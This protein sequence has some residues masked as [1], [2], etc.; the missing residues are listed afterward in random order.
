MAGFVV[1]FLVGIVCI[2]L[3]ASNM[4]GNIS[5]LHAYHRNRV[6][7]EDRV[8]FGKQVGLGTIMIGIGIMVFSALSAVT[9]YTEKDIFLLIGTVLLIGSIIAGLVLSFRAMIKYNTGIF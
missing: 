5:S 2:F 4:Q 1:T 6:S 9:L 3:G 8:P 7:E